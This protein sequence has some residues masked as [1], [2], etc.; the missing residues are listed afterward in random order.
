MDKIT[1]VSKGKVIIDNIHLPIGDTYKK[2]F[3][4]KLGSF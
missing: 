3:M 4:N 2:T 1:A